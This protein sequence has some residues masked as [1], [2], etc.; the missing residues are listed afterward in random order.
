MLEFNP[1]ASR[2]FASLRMTWSVWIVWRVESV[3]SVEFVWSVG[4]E[5]NG[6]GE[7]RRGVDFLSVFD[8]L[9]L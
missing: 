7:K 3:W 5:G 1:I 6:E 4:R 2:F 9:I 8:I